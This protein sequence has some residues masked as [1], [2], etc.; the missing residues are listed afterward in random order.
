MEKAAKGAIVWLHKKTLLVFGI[1]LVGLV[2][3]ISLLSQAILGDNF[4]DLEEK[5]TPSDYWRS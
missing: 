4:A 2:A 5:D 3:I 1:T